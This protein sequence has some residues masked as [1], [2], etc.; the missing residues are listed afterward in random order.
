[1]GIFT[2]SLHTTNYMA[3]RHQKHKVANQWQLYAC[4]SDLETV[5]LDKE[6][7]CAKLHALL[8]LLIPSYTLRDDKGR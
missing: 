2:W 5:V 7:Y 6:L 1:M 3:E 4:K 8:Q